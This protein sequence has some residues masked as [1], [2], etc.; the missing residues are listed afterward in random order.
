MFSYIIGE[1]NE[2]YSNSIGLEA[3]NIGY[4]VNVSNPYTFTIG[5]QIKIYIYNH[6]REDEYSLYGFKSVE[7]KE[8]FLRLIGVKGLGPKMAMPIIASSI[9]RTVSAINNEEVAY[10]KKF[11]KIGEKLAKQIILDLKGKLITNALDTFSKTDELEEVLLGLGYKK[12][13]ISKVV[14]NIDLDL[15]LENQIKQALKLLMK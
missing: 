10:L 15:S 6:I 5:Q 7:E 8:L 13:D 2:I 9:D 12:V 11:P 1:I 14:K 3:N 4:C